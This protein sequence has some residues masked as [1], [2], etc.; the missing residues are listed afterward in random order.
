MYRKKRI[1]SAEIDTMWFCATKKHEAYK[2]AV[3]KALTFLASKASLDHLEDL[4]SKVLQI[5]NKELDKFVLQLVR[6]IA[7]RLS[8]V[9]LTN[10]EPFRKRRDDIV[11]A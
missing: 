11:Y 8:G 4:F 3:L 7:R 2:V 5:P 9:D 10:L 1:G 6:A